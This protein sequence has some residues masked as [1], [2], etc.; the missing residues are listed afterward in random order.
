[1]KISA[2]TLTNRAAFSAS[3]AQRRESEHDAHPDGSAP[4]HGRD[5]AAPR[6]NLWTQ[7]HI[8]D[9]LQ[10][11]YHR[12]SN[13]NLGS[14]ERDGDVIAASDSSHGAPLEASMI[15]G[16]WTYRSYLNNPAP[17]GG[18]PQK[19]LNNIFGE[20]VFE[21][22]SADG[23]AVTGV[24]DMGGGYVLDLTGAAT[25]GADGSAGFRLSGIGRTGTPTDGW[26]YDY[27]GATAYAWP[28]AVAQVSTLVGS[29]IRAKPHDGGPA[30]VTA[31]FV[32]VHQP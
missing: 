32:A 5:Q 28:N 23:K 9:Y 26:E 12:S 29:V 25:L 2:E 8:E 10:L 16:K 20:G 7:G 13:A 27:A 17:V 22:A 31:S 24:F 21:L 6:L 19:A 30:G 14:G 18:D 3:T 1:V 4:A 15:A 11:L